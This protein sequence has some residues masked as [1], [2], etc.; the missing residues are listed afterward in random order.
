[1]THRTQRRGTTAV[2]SHACNRVGQIQDY[3][4]VCR[5]EAREQ[6]AREGYVVKS[7]KDASVKRGVH[8]SDPRAVQ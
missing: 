5:P 7:L 1:M 4:C 3:K 8:V 2:E 6:R